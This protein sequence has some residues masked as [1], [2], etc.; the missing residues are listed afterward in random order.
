MFT[1][2]LK[3]PQKGPEI[4]DAIVAYNAEMSERQPVFKASLMRQFASLGNRAAVKIIKKIPDAG[5]VLEPEAVDKL[6]IAAHCEIQRISEEFQHGRRVAELLKPILKALRQS[7]V[8]RKIRIIDIGCGTGFV[9]RWL[10]ASGALSD[11]VELIGADFNAALIREAERLAAVEKL[12]CE[13]V[14]ADAF[15]LNQPADIYISTGI[16]HHFRDASLA[17]LFRQQNRAETS[18]FV[19]FDFCSSPFAPFGAWLFHAVRMR[20]PLSKHDGVLSAV[21]AY[22]SPD[23]LKAARAGAPDFAVAVYGTRIWNLP[24]PRVFHS[25][26]GIRPRLREDFL[27]NL[28]EQRIRSLGVIE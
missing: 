4:S 16:L 2:W 19:H 8:R 1:D 13:F 7:G 15:R 27:K 24:I 14:V 17:E 25:L 23:L 9:L 21:R 12:N 26:V 10:A 22:K 6:L 28:G 11:D 3:I 20:E 5:G 18:A